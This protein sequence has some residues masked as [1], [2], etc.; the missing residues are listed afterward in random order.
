MSRSGYNAHVSAVNCWEI[1]LLNHHLIKMEISYVTNNEFSKL[2]I[3]P[4]AD[5]VKCDAAFVLLLKNLMRT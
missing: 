5:T 1:H 4:I 2:F 3:Q